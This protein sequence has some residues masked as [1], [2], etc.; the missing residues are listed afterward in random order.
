MTLT[1]VINHRVM[2]KH[3]PGRF[4]DGSKGE[5]PDINNLLAIYGRLLRSI[6]DNQP[7]IN[8]VKD[9]FEIVNKSLDSIIGEINWDNP[10]PGKSMEERAA[11]IANIKY[12]MVFNLNSV[13]F[14]THSDEMSDEMNEKD[15]LNHQSP[16]LT[17]LAGEFFVNNNVD[18]SSSMEEFYK[19]SYQKV[20]NYT[21]SCLE[22][23]TI[24]NNAKFS[25]QKELAEVMELDSNANFNALPKTY[26]EKLL[27]ALWKQYLSTPVGKQY[28]STPVG[29]KYL[30]V[31]SKKNLY[32][33]SLVGFDDTAISELS[34]VKTTTVESMAETMT[35]QPNFNQKE[36]D[37]MKGTLISN[38]HIGADHHDKDSIEMP[39]F[40]LRTK[41]T[42]EVGLKVSARTQGNMEFRGDLLR[43]MI[44]SV[45]S[46][47]P[48]TVYDAF[49]EHIRHLQHNG[50]LI[51]LINVLTNGVL[52]V[53]PKG[54][55]SD[56]DAKTTVYKAVKVQVSERL[57]KFF[58]QYSEGL[59]TYPDLLIKNVV[60]NGELTLKLT[61][62]GKEQCE[63][64]LMEINA[65]HPLPNDLVIFLNANRDFEQKLAVLSAQ[66]SSGNPFKLDSEEHKALKTLHESLDKAHWHLKDADSVS[67]P[68]NGG[69]RIYEFG[70]FKTECEKA[71][72]VAE[73]SALKHHRGWLDNILKPIIA[74]VLILCTLGAAVIFDFVEKY[75]EAGIMSITDGMK[76]V[77]AFKKAFRDIKATPAIPCAVVGFTAAGDGDGDGDAGA[78][79]TRPEEAPPS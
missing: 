8:T 38:V 37:W 61:P 25:N 40:E 44:I 14:A 5:L 55:L 46:G 47:K 52:A 4:F 9:F 35:E 53:K 48:Q 29:K 16:I 11:I 2:D 62:K 32:P 63:A 58:K 36:I 13:L 18:L 10:A 23:L 43:N 59:A 67:L 22:S 73:E 34:K 71:F 68:S 56:F 70:D 27:S 41:D 24:V 60:E 45:Q 19:R 21:S 72:L 6:G 74:C 33:I 54:F 64:I 28:L 7:N 50:N 30:S 15:K 79:D 75:A 65:L 69:S 76:T 26:K 31:T 66:I 1:T 20:L 49:Q 77:T 57:S 3:L 42:A 17:H 51:M 12:S 39:Y 78:D